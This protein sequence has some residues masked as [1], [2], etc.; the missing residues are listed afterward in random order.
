V[1]IVGAGVSGLCAGYELKKAGFNV[2]ILEAS[3]RVGGRVKTFREPTFAHGLHGEG[4]A[5]RIPKNHFLL[6]RYIKKFGL[7]HQL[8]DFEMKNK[9]IY[10][11]G[12]GKTL[13]YS[14]FNHLLKNRDKDLLA[15][16]PGLRLSE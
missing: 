11:S 3:S 8:F 7:E 10:I 4:G 14:E 1:T 2:T 5:M 9:F 15:L 16:F 12:Y 6:H 13:T